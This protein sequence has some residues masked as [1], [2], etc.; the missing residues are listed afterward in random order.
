[1]KHLQ[2]PTKAWQKIATACV[3]GLA[4][5]SASTSSFAAGTAAGT[6][7]T[8]KAILSFSVGGV[9]QTGI[10]SSPTGNTVPGVGAGTNT[11][12]VVD[13]KVSLLVAT[14]DTAPVTVAPGTTQRVTRYTVTNTGNATQ[15]FIL[16]TADLATGTAITLGGA[17]TDNFALG[18]TC[19]IRVDS[20]ANNGV[21][22]ASV[23]TATYID[24]LAA[25]Q[26]KSV[27]VLCDIPAG[28]LNSDVAV[29]SLTAQAAQSG[30]VGTLGAVQTEDTGADVAA[31]VQT[32]FG[33]IA[34]SDDIARDGK[35]SSRSAY[36][37]ISAVLSV[38]KTE[39]VVCDPFNGNTN[40]KHIPGAIVKYAITVSNAGTAG[41]SATLGSIADTLN[42]NLAFDANFVLG[43]T[44]ANCNSAT[45]A[46][47]NA[48]GR[49]FRLVCGGTTTR[50][51]TT[52]QFLTSTNADTDGANH[53]AGT[54]NAAYG[55][56]LPAGTF[57]ANTY[58]AG[59]LKP[60][61]N[62]TIEFQVTVN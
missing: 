55:D 47:T 30:T 15:D 5:L 11:T 38:Q 35:H 16:S 25:D 6:S 60:G 1:M 61:E 52:A 13:R 22:D 33:D 4:G 10:E 46:A 24:E 19:A 42:T 49:G 56:A 62:V 17:F 37:V 50:A 29:V 28:Q 14:V 43:N 34:G 2:H 9:S 12:F 39:A 36:R 20:S 3:L 51:C 27:F 44:V 58:G 53:N 40:A 8:N 18:A 59:E 7:I 54:V 32:V 31:T 23:D 41:A 21:Y 45:G 48:A 26:V 57:G